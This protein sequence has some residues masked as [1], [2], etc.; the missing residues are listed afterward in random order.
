M[1]RPTPKRNENRINPLPWSA[2]M[3]ASESSPA[4]PAAFV[5]GRNCSKIETRNSVAVLMIS[6]MNSAM[7]RSMSMVP[8]RSDGSIGLAGCIKPGPR[9]D[10]GAL[11]LS[12]QQFPQFRFRHLLQRRA[13]HLV[14]EADLARHLEIRERTAA[15][16]HHGVVQIRRRAFDASLRNDEHHRH[17]I[18]HRMLFRNHRGLAHA[19]H[20]RYHL[21]DLRGRDVLAADLQHVLGA[22]AEFDEA[23]IQ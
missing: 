18:E 17:L 14:D 20:D 8:M 6:T 2:R 12:S 10:N 4:N 3:T 16:G 15:G 11:A 23:V 19:G 9:N 5:P 13:R 22:V 1:A 7:P 21:L